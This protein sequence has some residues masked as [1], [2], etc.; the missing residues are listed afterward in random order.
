MYHCSFEFISNFRFSF[1][2]F[3]KS[4]KGCCDSLGVK[5]IPTFLRTVGSLKMM[6][7]RSPKV[8]EVAQ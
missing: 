5:G 6:F 1:K 2:M 8:L 4:L 7:C 3:A